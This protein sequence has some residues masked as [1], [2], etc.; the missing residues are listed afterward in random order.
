MK[1]SGILSTRERWLEIQPTL[2]GPMHK[3]L[4]AATYPEFHGR[5]GRVD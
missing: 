3:I 2:K 5:E 4:F 1:S